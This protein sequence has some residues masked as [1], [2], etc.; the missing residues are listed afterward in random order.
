[1]CNCSGIRLVCKASA[2]IDRRYCPFARQIAETELQILQLDQDFRTEVLKDLREPQARSR[3][4]R[5]AQCSRDEL[6]R[7]DIRAPS[8]N[9]LSA[10][11][12]SIGGVIGKGDTVMQIARAPTP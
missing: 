3:N 9:Y 1:M 10:P 12:P 7:T 11:G 6:K 2:V 8:G 5:S 4:C